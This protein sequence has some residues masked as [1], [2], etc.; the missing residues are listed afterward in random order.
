MP[1]LHHYPLRLASRSRTCFLVVPNH[2]PCRPALASW[3]PPCESNAATRRLEGAAGRPARWG[4]VR[5]GRVELP[6]PCGHKV[7][8]LARLPFRHHRR[9]PARRASTPR[10]TMEP[11][12]GIGPSEPTLRGSAVPSTEGLIRRRSPLASHP[13][14]AVYL[15][16]AVATRLTGL[17]LVRVVVAVR[18]LGF[19]PRSDCF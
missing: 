12:L 17:S 11:S 18:T 10:P 14:L 8:S 9:R 13:G 4:H 1:P 19:E 15:A 7:L 16:C 2:V 6:R 5:R 3:S